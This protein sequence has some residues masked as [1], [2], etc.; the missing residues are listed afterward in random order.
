MTV[1]SAR[2]VVVTLDGNRILTGVD[3]SAG[4]G[5]WLAVIGPNGAGKSTLLRTLA[6]VLRHEGEVTVD[7]APLGGM[8]PRE[9][10]RRIA[11]A[12]Q[13]PVLPSEVAV[14]D[15]VLLGR[16]PHL[17]YLAR[18]GRHDRDVTRD[19]LRRLDLTGLAGR[20]MGALSGGEAQR[21]LIARALA[22]EAAVLLLDEPTTAL[23]LGHQQQV[24]ELIDGL[25]RDDGLTVISTLHDLTLAGQYADRLLLL[26]DGRTVAE[27]PPARVLEAATIARHY[28]ARV[29]VETDPDGRPQVRL[30]RPGG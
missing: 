12:P 6:G 26:V 9:R 24:L 10:A 1:I 2:G 17:G 23:D 3:A 22:Q 4:A 7:G 20:R 30:V 29:R 18:E 21:V 28:G 11:Y 5:E 25:R 19:V 27:G 15:Y 16:T 8:S 14:F 13:Q